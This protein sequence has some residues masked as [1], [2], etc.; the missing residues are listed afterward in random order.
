MADDIENQDPQPQAESG[1][2]AAPG[3]SGAMIRLAILIAV[4]AASACGGVAAGKFLKASGTPDGAPTSAQAGGQGIVDQQAGP[5]SDFLYYTFPPITVNLNEPAMSRYIKM[6]I[7]LAI[8]PADFK[9]AEEVLKKKE[10]EVISRLTEFLADFTLTDLN[11]TEN[12]NRLLRSIEDRLNDQ[13]WP[14]QRRLI[15]HVLFKE[16]WIQ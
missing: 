2:E 12:L 8:A 15:D 10:P 1:A 13:L 3:K 11:G 7:V 16:F 4:M 14:D 6:H 9:E 5:D